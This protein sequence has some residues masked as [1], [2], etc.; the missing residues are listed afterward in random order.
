MVRNRWEWVVRNRWE[1]VIRNRWEWVVRNRWVWVVRNRREW[2]VRNR[3]EWV[4]RNR[5]EWVVRNRREWVWL[6]YTG[7]TSSWTGWL[8]TGGNGWLGTGG[9]RWFGTG[10]NGRCRTGGNGWLGTG[11]NGWFGI[12]GNWWLGTGGNWWLGIGGNG[13]FRTD[14]NGWFGTGGYRWWGTGE[15]GCGLTTQVR[16]AVK[17]GGWE[18]VGMG[19][20]WQHR[21]DKQSSWVIRIIF[22]L[23]LFHSSHYISRVQMLLCFSSP[24]SQFIPALKGNTVRFVL[25]ISCHHCPFQSGK[26]AMSG[27][28]PSS[29]ATCSPCW[30][31]CKQKVCPRQRCLL[32]WAALVSR[33][34]SWVMCTDIRFFCQET[35]FHQLRRGRHHCWEKF[36]QLIKGYKLR[37][38]WQK[39]N[40]L[41]VRT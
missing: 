32:C 3:W 6:D 39:L 20:V 34:V 11:G 16:L 14:G 8:G 27:S 36:L 26:G 12:G 9:N 31:R 30:P 23:L 22:L 7:E 21:W 15:N 40:W 28:G 29:G 18:Q 35:E 19:V 2:V 24:L 33:T 25:V 37:L 5:W 41:K 1:W 38:V 4:V 13:W 10:G 17:L